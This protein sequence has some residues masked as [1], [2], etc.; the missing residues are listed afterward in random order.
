MSRICWQTIFI[1][2]KPHWYGKSLKQ[3]GFLSRQRDIR[4][5]TG[6]NSVN[7]VAARLVRGGEV[8]RDGAGLFTSVVLPPIVTIDCG[9]GCRAGTNGPQTRAVPLPI[10]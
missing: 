6:A 9:Q 2:G 7:L 4:R 3:L 1:C 10:Q 5:V 8:G